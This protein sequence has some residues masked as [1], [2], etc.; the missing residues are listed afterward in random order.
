MAE[1]VRSVPA[2]AL[3]DEVLISNYPLK[4]NVGER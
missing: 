2:F 4:S 1:N 3:G